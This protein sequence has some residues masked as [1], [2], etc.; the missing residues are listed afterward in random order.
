MYQM[1]AT[2]EPDLKPDRARF[3]KDRRNL[4][5]CAVGVLCR[6]HP[7]RTQ[8]PKILAQIAALALANG[9][10]DPTAIKIAPLWRGIGTG[11]GIG[12]VRQRAL[13]FGFVTHARPHAAPHTARQAQSLR[14]TRFIFAQI[15]P[16]EASPPA[17]TSNI[18]P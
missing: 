13:G 11:I 14:P 10:A 5:R 9:L 2:A 16:P 4:D 6:R 17:T 18:G 1:L 3:A 15:S 7:M 12:V 8:R